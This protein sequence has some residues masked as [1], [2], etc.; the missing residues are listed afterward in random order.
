MRG[1]VWSIALRIDAQ[2]GEASAS[3]LM[4]HTAELGADAPLGNVSAFGL[5]ADGELYVV[6]YSRG[7]VSKVIVPSSAP[8]APTG[9]RIIR[10]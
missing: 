1:R 10:P 3:D 6:G 8:A 4:E 9:L 5:D 7:T 2:T